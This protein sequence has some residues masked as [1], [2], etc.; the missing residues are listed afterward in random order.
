VAVVRGGAAPR[1]DGA[2]AL[3]TVEICLAMLE[4]ARSGRDIALHHQDA[5]D[6]GSRR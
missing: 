3:A 5:A 1:H 2:S 6:P 4:S